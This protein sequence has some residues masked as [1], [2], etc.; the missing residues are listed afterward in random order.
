MNKKIKVC[1]VVSGLKSGGVETMIYNY[2]TN[3]SK[4]KFEWYVIYQHE[5]SEKNLK[6]FKQAGFN[7]KRIHS[8]TKNP[9]KNYIDTYIFLKENNIDVVHAHMTLMNFIPLIAAKKLKIKIRISHSHNCFFDR[10]IFKKI[11]AYLCKK[12]I[13][14]NSTVCLAC[15]EEAG[16]YLYK[17]DEYIIINNALDLNKFMFNKVSRRKIR[18]EYKITDDMFV[19]GHVGRFVEQKNHIFLLNVLKKIVEEN[20]KTILVLIGDGK[21]KK[22]MMKKAQELGI[23]NNVIFVGIVE[24]INEFYS[25]IDCF[26]LPSLWEG[27]PVVAIEAQCSGV[28]CIFSNNIDMNVKINNNISFLKLDEDEWKR[29]IIYIENKNLNNRTINKDLFINKHYSIID[30]AKRLEK[31]YE[32]EIYN[33]T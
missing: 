16:K 4:E 25:A 3:M 32:G 20:E 23:N 17:K 6:E 18:T 27:L 8:K 5:A 10:N 21:L 15:G 31:I 28:D 24:N 13:K 29:K 30:E 19:I 11:F 33:E 22:D 1:H 9:I 14:K 2:C 12:I 26:C 7:L